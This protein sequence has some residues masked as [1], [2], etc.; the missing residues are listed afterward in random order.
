[1]KSD[2]AR[3][4]PKVTMPNQP[5]AA[6]SAASP[7]VETIQTHHV[8]NSGPDTSATSLYRP[9]DPAFIADPYPAYARLR[10]EGR[11]HWFEPSHQW[12]VPH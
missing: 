7:P 5:S 3:S 2:I 9:W 10:Q 12:L 6:E 11:V 4:Y 1:M 8:D